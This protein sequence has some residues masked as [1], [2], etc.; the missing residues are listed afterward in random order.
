MQFE[1]NMIRRGLLMAE[2]EI[3]Q[4]YGSYVHRLA[5]VCP[6]EEKIHPCGLERFT[7]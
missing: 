3:I 1:Y 5:S 6:D 7:K 2:E 4:I